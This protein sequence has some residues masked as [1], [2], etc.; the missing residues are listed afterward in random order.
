M[1]NVVTKKLDPLS[2]GT[3]FG[4]TWS[5][6]ISALGVIATYSGQGIEAVEFISTIYIGFDATL[7]GTAIGATW[8]LIDGL[9]VG[10]IFAFVYNKSNQLFEDKLY[11]EIDTEEEKTKE[12]EE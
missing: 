7:T 12:E 1:L 4:I 11:R 2:L 9:V 8:A 6:L 5:L 3:A 10:L